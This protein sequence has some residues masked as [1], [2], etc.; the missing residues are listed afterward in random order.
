MQRPELPS[1]QHSLPLPPD[2]SS[3]RDLAGWNR[4]R[5]H[6]LVARLHDRRGKGRGQ[7]LPRRHRAHIFADQLVYARLQ[8]RISLILHVADVAVAPLR[9]GPRILGRTQD[10][11]PDEDHEIGLGTRPAARLEQLADERDVTEERYL[12]QGAPLVVVEQAADA[13]DLSIV[14]GDRG[15][16]LALVEDEVVEVVGHGA[17][18]R[19]HLLAQIELDGAAGVDLGL[20]LEDDADFLALD[21][22]EGIVEIVAER[23]AGRDR[24]FLTDQD[25]RF[26]VVERHDRR[27][28]QD[29]GIIVALNGVDDRAEDRVAAAE[30]TAAEKPGRAGQ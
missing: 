24:D 25:A 3:L 28:R 8:V 7:P 18:D 20:Y 4:R 29:V 30:G 11:R 21:G 13:D 16:D 9:H 2:Q 17:G 14:D 12:L 15:L 19:A 26:L 5:L 23:L 22:A 27:R 10:G 6:H 1:R